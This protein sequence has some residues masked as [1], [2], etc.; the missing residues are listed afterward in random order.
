MDT[1]DVIRQELRTRMARIEALNN[2]AR[3]L[4]ERDDFIHAADRLKKIAHQ[5]EFDSFAMNIFA[6][7]SSGDNPPARRIDGSVDEYLA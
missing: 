7:M 1:K 5:G 3:D 6:V 4:V 2:Q